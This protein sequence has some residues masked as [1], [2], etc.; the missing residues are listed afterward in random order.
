[1]AIQ[2][3]SQKCTGCNYC[4]LTCQANA[5]TLNIEATTWPSIDEVKCIRCGDCLYICPNKVF[6]DNDLVAEPA[7]IKDH[8]DAIIIGAGIGGLLAAAGLARAGKKVVILEQMSFIGGKYTHLNHD[9]YAISTA[10]WTCV[11]PHSRIGKLCARLGADIDW[12]T[13]HDV[14]STGDHWVVTRD[15]RRFVSLDEAQTAIVGGHQGMVKVLRWIADMYDPG[16]THPDDMTARQYIQKFVPDNEEYKKYVETIITHCFASQTV[17][18]FSATETKRATVD[19]IEQMAVWGTARGGT[20]ALVKALEKVILDNGSE[21]ITRTGVSS[22]AIENG[23][24][25]GVVLEDGRLI[26]ADNVIH[27]AGLN[28]FLK[29]AGESNLPASY[30]TRLRAAIPAN[31][32]TLILGT[33][34]PLLGSGHSL[35]HTMGWERTLNCYAPTFFD[36]GL[37][38]QGKHILDVF[39]AMQPPYDIK[40]ELDL[41]LSQLHQVFPNYDQVV[42]LQAPLFYTGAWTAEMAHRIGQSGADRL[43]PKS[44]I[45]NLYLVGYDCIGYG[46]AGDII[47]HGVERALYLILNDPA[48]APR[49]EKSSVLFNKWLKSQIFKGLAFVEQFKK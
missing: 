10:A 47:P 13:I 30:V 25:I 41:V 9:G 12:I 15:G 43:E 24:A 37:A 34:E 22:I 11:G 40:Q 45:E 36:P 32:A 49:D 3:E 29:L 2:I 39:W 27:N 48:Y 38:P 23:K 26:K 42:E 17:D 6:S 44:P 8:Y 14:K 16:S 35:L 4:A 28:R 18:N 31:V 33:D 19:S 46:I 21:I 7:I 5:I 20:L 1:M